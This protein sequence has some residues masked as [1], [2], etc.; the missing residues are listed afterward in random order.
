[1]MISWMRIVKS[2]KLMSDDE[3]DKISKVGKSMLQR[4]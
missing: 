3:L 4:E 1:M 2:I